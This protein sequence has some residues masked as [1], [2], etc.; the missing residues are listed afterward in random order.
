MRLAAGDT[1]G[2]YRIAGLIGAGGMGEVYRARDTRLDRDVALK[3]LPDEFTNSAERLAR[4]Q[5]EA[6]T[7]ASLNHPHIAQI[8]GLEELP[9]RVALAMELVEGE[10]LAV[11]GGRGWIV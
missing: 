7:L 9:D 2:A 1:L 8:Y 4:F 6:R 11:Q 3:L 10:N 5:R